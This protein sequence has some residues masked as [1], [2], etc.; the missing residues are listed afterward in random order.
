VCAG[1]H[2]VKDPKGDWITVGKIVGTHGIRGVLKLVS[3]AESNALFAPG[4]AL[5]FGRKDK[6]RQTFRI[7]SSRPHKRVIL[8]S[9]DGI[10]SIET[11]QAW[12]GCEVYVKKGT[13]APTEQGTYYWHEIIGM[14]V[15]TLTDEHLGQVKAIFP[16]GSNDVY[17]VRDGDKEVLIPAIDSVVL[18][19]DPDKNTMTVDLPE[20]LKA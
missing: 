8:L 18:D 11:A 14:K 20:G 2:R 16:T 6:A 19:I 7:T 9:V 13:L 5:A 15:V 17:V 4:K 10:A 3:F 12:L 1:N